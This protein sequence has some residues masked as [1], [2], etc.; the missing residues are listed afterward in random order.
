VFFSFCFF[1]LLELLIFIKAVKD[2]L[3]QNSLYGVHF[4]EAKI[5]FLMIRDVNLMLK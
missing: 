2:L 5:D 1:Y 3:Y 4:V